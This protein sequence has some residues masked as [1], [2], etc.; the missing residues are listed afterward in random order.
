[1]LKD[2]AAGVYCIHGKDKAKLR[3]KEVCPLSVTNILGS[4]RQRGHTEVCRGVQ[5]EVSLL[6]KIRL[7]TGIAGDKADGA[8]TAIAGGA[9]TGHTGGGVIF[10]TEIVR[11]LRVR[12]GEAAKIEVR[13][14]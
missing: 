4:G 9:R 5:T 3:A 12:A 14:G 6:R 10:V 11:I 13:P 8:I 7:E 1:M 2:A